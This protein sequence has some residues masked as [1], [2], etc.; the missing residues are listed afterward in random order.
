M[1][2]DILRPSEIFT[3]NKYLISVKTM[4]CYSNLKI[5]QLTTNLVFKSTLTSYHQVIML[6]L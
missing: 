1:N 4:V 3:E 2:R 6:S 5:P